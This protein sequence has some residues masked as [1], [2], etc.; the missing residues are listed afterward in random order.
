M[1]LT[2]TPS[3][4]ATKVAST[5]NECATIVSIGPCRSDRASIAAA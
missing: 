4:T 2:V 1:R 5:P 3:R